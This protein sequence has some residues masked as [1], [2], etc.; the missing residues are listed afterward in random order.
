[1]NKRFHAQLSKLLVDAEDLYIKGEKRLLK[2]EVRDDFEDRFW[3]LLSKNKSKLDEES[4]LEFERDFEIRP[5][6]WH[7]QGELFLHEENALRSI[8][9]RKEL[10]ERV[11]DRAT[12]KLPADSA[13]IQA[14]KQYTAKVYLRKILSGSN[15]IHFVDNFFNPVM[16]ELLEELLEINPNT[17]IEILRSEPKN[18]N[19]QAVVRTLINDVTA[20]NKQYSD[21]IKTLK[22]TNN[23]PLHDRFLIIDS[24]VYHSGHSF[25]GIGEKASR[26]N[27]VKEPS[28]IKRITDDINN[29]MSSGK[30]LI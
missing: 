13:Y 3:D 24:K 28:E 26:I 15:N 21:A 8:K 27:L 19:D 6:R 22:T 18:K 7:K 17:K 10:I 25:H 4:Q 29:W 14:G 1:M 30:N 12:V 5:T 11:L 16:L 23:L 20:F 9:P 2:V